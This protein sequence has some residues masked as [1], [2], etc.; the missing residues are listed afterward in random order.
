MSERELTPA[1]QERDTLEIYVSDEGEVALRT[2][3]EKTG[4][5]KTTL[6]NEGLKLL[7][8]EMAISDAGGRIL[9]QPA[10][11]QDWEEVRFKHSPP[12]PP[13]T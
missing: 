7:A 6:C 4:L 2:L 5:N 13:G 12:P 10:P 1:E 8:M 11:G 3:M 9:I